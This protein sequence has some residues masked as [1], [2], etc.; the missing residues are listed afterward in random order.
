[1]ADDM[2]QLLTV[3]ETVQWLKNNNY[4]ISDYGL[5]Y[6]NKYILQLINDYLYIDNLFHKNLLCLNDDDISKDRTLKMYVQIKYFEKYLGKVSIKIGTEDKYG[7]LHYKEVLDEEDEIIKTKTGTVKYLLNI[8][9]VR[10]LDFFLEDYYFKK[11]SIV[12]YKTKSKIL[13][14]ITDLTT[15]ELVEYVNKF[16]TELEKIIKR[17]LSESSDIITT[18][19]NRLY[20]SLERN[21]EEEITISES[22]INQVEELVSLM[23]EEVP[24]LPEGVFNK[25]SN[26]ITRTINSGEYN[27]D[28]ENLANRMHRFLRDYSKNFY[29]EIPE[30][31]YKPMNT[32]QI[33]KEIHS[34]VDKRQF[35]LYSELFSIQARLLRNKMKE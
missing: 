24:R 32:E 10:A 15:Q 26:G 20:Q 7:K 22:I 13:N 14:E 4:I 25:F 34:I 23:S 17:Y 6:S 3:D 18:E 9:F 35:S 2:E 11:Q 27:E 28:R 8:N 5:E 16:I 30:Q 21:L 31:F 29:E 1:M 12:I 19:K 33:V